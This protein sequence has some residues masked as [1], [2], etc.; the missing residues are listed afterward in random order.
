MTFST[1][2]TWIECAIHELRNC[3][4]VCICIY[5]Y[6]QCVNWM[7]RNGCK[8]FPFL[9]TECNY[10]AW[11]EVLRNSRRY[12]HSALLPIEPNKMGELKI[13]SAYFS[14]SCQSESKMG[15]RIVI[16]IDISPLIWMHVEETMFA[17][18]TTSKKRFKNN[19]SNGIN[20]NPKI[21]HAPRKHINTNT[22]SHTAWKINPNE[23]K[24]A[25]QR[26]GKKQ[27]EATKTTKNR[28][29]KERMYTRIND[30]RTIFAMHSAH[31]ILCTYKHSAIILIFV[32]IP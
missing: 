15:G 1:R 19:R 6:T 5:L 32:F 3:W 21:S 17:Q 7:R 8:T 25:N 9:C 31:C 22:Q 28:A 11:T 12:L 24:I 26:A 23:H 4:C 20:K 2:Q 14:S 16:G 29:N 10:R 30:T 18:T 27:M 13:F